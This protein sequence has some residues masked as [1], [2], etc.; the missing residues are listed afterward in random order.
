MNGQ[1]QG[2]DSLKTPSSITA[3]ELNLSRNQLRIM[4]GFSTGHC[5]LKGHLFKLG[6]VNSP[7]CD[8][9]QQASQM[10]SHI[11]CDCGPLATLRFR[12]LSHHFMESGDIEDMSLNKTLHFVQDVELLNV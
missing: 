3:G 8:R 1:G 10:A 6:L 12:H 4:T 9:R 5:H 11:L 7:P 2:K